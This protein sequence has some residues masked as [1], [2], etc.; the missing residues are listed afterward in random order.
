[1]LR[2]GLVFGAYKPV[3]T[4]ALHEAK[5]KFYQISKKEGG[6]CQIEEISAQ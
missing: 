2:A 4:L 6:A 1:M 3:V 5:I